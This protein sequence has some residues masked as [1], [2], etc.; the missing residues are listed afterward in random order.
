MTNATLPRLL[1]TLGDVAGIGP[2]IVARAWPRLLDLCRPTVVGDPHWLRRAL[3]LVAGSTA[4]VRVDI[5][6]HPSQCSPASIAFPVFPAARSICAQ[7]NQDVSAPRRG[8]RRMT[9][10]A[11]PSTDAGRLRGRHR[12]G[13]AAQGR[14]A[15]GGPALSRAHRDPGRA[16]RGARTSPWCS[17]C[18]VWRWPMS[19]CTWPCAT[20]FAI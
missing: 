14:S 11:G 5:I 15:R 20:S 17:R 1:I 9:S 12:D 13:S 3:D 6:E 10:C 7:S 2:E 4:P 16:D 19:R 18:R 8:G